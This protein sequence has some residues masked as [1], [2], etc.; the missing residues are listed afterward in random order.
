MP[1][2][3]TTSYATGDD[4]NLLHGDSDLV[5]FT[6]LRNKN[7]FGNYLRF[8]DVT[9]KAV[10]PGTTTYNIDH[11]TGLGFTIGQAANT[12]AIHLANALTHSVTVGGQVFSGFWLPNIKELDTIRTYDS[13]YGLSVVLESTDIWTSDTDVTTT[14]NAMVAASANRYVSVVKTSAT[15]RAIYFRNHF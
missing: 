10:V 8:T 15:R 2:G 6:T 11:Y 3:V 14:A 4:G 7:I 13:T 9:G 1:T 12:W 5:N